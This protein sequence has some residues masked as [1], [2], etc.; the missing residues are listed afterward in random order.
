LPIA[1]GTGVHRPGSG[2]CLPGATTLDV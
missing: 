2:G 1:T